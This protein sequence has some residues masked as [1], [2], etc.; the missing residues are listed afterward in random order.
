MATTKSYSVVWTDNGQ[1][2]VDPR[3]QSATAADALREGE[4]LALECGEYEP[5]QHVGHVVAPDGEWLDRVV[6]PG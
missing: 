2:V 4:R 5:G 3:V 6:V 1:R